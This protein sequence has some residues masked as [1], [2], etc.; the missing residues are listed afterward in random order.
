MRLLGITVVAG[1][2]VLPASAPLAWAD[3]TGSVPDFKQVYDLIKQNAAGVT[4]ADLNR[5]AVEGLVR[6]MGAKVSL[7]TNGVVVSD[8]SPEPL[9]K[10]PQV[11]LDDV[12]YLR[13]GSVGGNLAA[14]VQNACD[15][16]A[17]SNQIKGVVLDLRYAGGS[18]YVAAAAVVDLFTSKAESLLFWEGQTISS[19]EKTNAIH[20][21]VAVLVNA[22]TTG[23]A[24]ALAA[25]FR[26][27]GSGLILGR[28]TAGRALATKSFPLTGGAEL[29]IATGPI[30]LGDG[31]KLSASGL[32]PDINVPVNPE[33]ERAYYAD[34]FRQLTRTNSVGDD[35]LAANGQTGDTNRARPRFNEAELVR[36]RAG[37]TAVAAPEPAPDKPV[38][39]DPVLA[40]ALDL[41]K[42]LA[43]VRRWQS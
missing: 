16:L 12:A 7:V 10:K 24:E 22:E 14:A 31:S 6:E 20:L 35:A 34:A 19:H 26:E 25:M 27:T 37:A 8:A 32:K 33:D 18:D 29:R 11:L 2:L 30:T 13:I 28:P 38:V 40:R 9:T 4:D 43:V 41:L 3:G 5:A 39:N 17:V 23:A 42:G 21:P 36:E 1:L 15:Q